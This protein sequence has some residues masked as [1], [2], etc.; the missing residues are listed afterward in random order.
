MI[1]PDDKHTLVFVSFGVGMLNHVKQLS[2]G[3]AEYDL[4]EGD[5]TFSLEEPTFFRTPDKQSDD[6]S[7]SRCVP[8]G[9]TPQATD[10]YYGRRFFGN[11]IGSFVRRMPSY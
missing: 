6:Q 8:F 10:E 4:L 9:N 5:T 1:E 2:T 7:V 3:N 11:A